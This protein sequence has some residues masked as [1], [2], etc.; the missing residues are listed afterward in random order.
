MSLKII[1]SILFASLI[2]GSLTL[3]PRNELPLAKSGERDLTSYK[4]E[5]R[6]ESSKIGPLYKF[7][8]NIVYIYE[9]KRRIFLKLMD[10]KIPIEYAGKLAFVSSNKKENSGSV[11]AHF[12]HYT[13]DE[14]PFH[15]TPD[16][17]VSFNSSGE[18]VILMGSN[19]QSNQK[20][21]LAKD[22]VNLFFFPIREDSTGKYEAK[23][24]WSESGKGLL[25]KKTK[26]KYYSEINT[27]AIIESDHLARWDSDLNLPA[28]IWGKETTRL[29]EMP[30]GIEAL[31]QYEIKFLKQEKLSSSFVWSEAMFG[32]GLSWRVAQNIA[33]NSG[34]EKISQEEVL[35][36]LR[37]LNTL[38]QNE[39]LI[40]FGDILTL[41]KE[42]E[43]NVSELLALLNDSLNT[44]ERG[45]LFK[46]IVGSL[47]TNGSSES[48]AELVGLYSDSQ[49]SLEEKVTI[50]AALATS[51]AVIDSKTRDFLS[52]TYSQEKD[53]K[54]REGAA[55]AYGSSLSSLSKEASTQELASIFN[56]WNALGAGPHSEKLVLLD[57]IGNS[58]RSEFL[59]LVNQ[60]YLMGDKTY[61]NKSIMA[62][63][64]MSG[65]GSIAF[66]I[67]ALMH[68]ESAIRYVAT[69]AI[70][71]GQWSEQFRSPVSSCGLSD[72]AAEVR[73]QCQEIMKANSSLVAGR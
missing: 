23:I 58:G 44:G 50:L 36:K 49:T 65:S 11:F 31:S 33:K 2:L 6:L 3:K 38:S 69:Q 12:S 20:F 24:S 72:P 60:A 61:Q 66:L 62:A 55:Y 28:H 73:L 22:S 53:V 70:R 35:A 5:G 57:L 71:L 26:Q 43:L 48:L 21:E 67:N 8:K 9:I 41:L 10:K 56:R 37:Q 29:G 40:L 19:S 63:R 18:S 52:N 45:S 34:P 51:E 27:P 16:L 17:L 32:V 39:Q 13:D 42:N 30:S 47:A 4:H 64:G 68:N 46:M 15:S 54:L 1:G 7:E 25:G 59:P 14:I